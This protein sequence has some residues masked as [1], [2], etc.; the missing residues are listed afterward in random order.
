MSSLNEP[1]QSS[2]QST[3]LAEPPIRKARKSVPFGPP[4]AFKRRF[5]DKQVEKIVAPFIEVPSYS[6]LMERSTEVLSVGLYLIELL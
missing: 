3:T 2:E 6:Q 5:V 1:P 4:I